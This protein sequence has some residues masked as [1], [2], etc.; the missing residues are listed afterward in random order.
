MTDWQT[1]FERQ[2]AMYPQ[3]LLQDMLKALHQSLLGCGHLV[4]DEKVQV[5]MVSYG[6]D[7]QFLSMEKAALTQTE[8]NTYSAKAD[9]HNDGS[10]AKVTI[11][12]LDN[13]N[14]IPLAQKQELNKQAR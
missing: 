8:L 13:G 1:L 3:V 10:V 11:L 4:E 6:D 7:G 14:W 9:I 12:V 5:L 2:K